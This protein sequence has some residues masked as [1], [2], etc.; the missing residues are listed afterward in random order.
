M[1]KH[2]SFYTLKNI[3]PGSCEQKRLM[4]TLQW[5]ARLAFM[6]ELGSHFRGSIDDTS[7]PTIVDYFSQDATMAPGLQLVP[8]RISSNNGQIVDWRPWEEVKTAAT[9]TTSLAVKHNLCTS[10]VVAKA[11]K[12]SDKSNMLNTNFD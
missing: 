5:G 12:I 6:A 8:G 1:D 9:L 3:E 7:L 4:K 11:L 10:W 2:T